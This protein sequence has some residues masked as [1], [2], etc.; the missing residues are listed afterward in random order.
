MKLDEFLCSRQVAFETLSHPR[1]YTANYMAQCLH[2]PGR[3]VAKTVLLRTSDG[4]VLCV[5]PAT[6][7]VDLDRVREILRDP[8]VELATESEIERLFPDC[9]VGA[10]PPFGS[11]YDIPTLVDEALAR[12]ENIFFEGCT[13]E[14]AIRMSYR[15]FEAIEHPPAAAFASPM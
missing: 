7:I 3:E 2:V 1:T 11:L 14:E 8:G 4:H 5:L 6:H 13:H 10:I 12:D 9:E 15:D